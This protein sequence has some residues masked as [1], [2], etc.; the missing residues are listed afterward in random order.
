MADRTSHMFDE[1]WKNQCMEMSLQPLMLCSCLES[2][3]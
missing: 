2:H 1:N 3:L